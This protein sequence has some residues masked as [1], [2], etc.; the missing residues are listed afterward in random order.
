MKTTSRFSEGLGLMAGAI[1]LFF[2]GLLFAETP[3]PALVD[4]AV[5]VHKRPVPLSAGARSFLTQTNTPEVKVWVFFTDKQVFSKD[6]FHAQA[7][8]VT[9]LEKVL[10]RRAKVDMD[11]VLFVDL[12]VA[13]SYVNEIAALGGRL[14]HTSK[15]LNAASFEI[16]IEQLDKVASLPFVADVR[17]VAAFK[18]P[19]E[20]LGSSEIDDP[21]PPLSPD[22]LNYGNSFAQLNQINVPAVHAK[23][24]HGEGVTLAMFDTGYRKSHQVF[25]AHYAQGRV[26]AEWDFI[27][28]DGNTANEAVDWS[29]QWDHGTY[30]WST[31]GGSQDGVQ[32]GPAYKANFLLAKTEDVRSETRVEEDNWVAA[33]EWADGLGADVVTSSLGYSDWYT[34]ADFDGSTATTTLAANTAAGL[35]IVVC[36]SMGNGGPAAGTL[37]APADAFDI[38]AV[39]AV[40]S[41]GL[42]ASFSSRGPTYDGR[43]KPEVCARGVGTTCATSASD[44]SYGSASGTSLSTPLVAGAACLLIQ[45]RPSFTPQLIRAA[46]MET[47]S[48]ATTSDNTYG[49]GIIDVNKALTWGVNFYADTTFASGPLTV[50]FFD[51]S[52]VGPTNWAWSFG[53]GGFSN[54]QNPTHY[55][56]NPGAYDVSLTVGSSYG[57]I[58]EIKANY[59]ILLG[60]TAWFRTDSAFAGDQV[61]M[62]VDIVNSQPLDKVVI[63]FKFESTPNLG[64]SF[65]SVA[66]G[67][68]TNYF[69]KKQFLQSD[70]QNRKYTVELTADN[71]GGAPPLTPGTGEVLKIYFTLDRYAFGSQSN[72]VD[73][74]SG[75]YQLT[76]T[77]DDFNYQPVVYA[78]QIR[79]IYVLRGDVDHTLTHNVADISFLVA[80]LFQG[81]QEPVSF[82]AG[83][84]NRNFA[85]NVDDLTYM[86]AYLFQ[87]GPPP[88]TP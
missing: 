60:D 35:G 30:I 66:F 49:W 19:L 6:E 47:A 84:A 50:Q 82:Q 52:T 1:V 73:S 41:T 71:G 54:D 36:N 23:G 22:A 81:G 56:E 17:P 46:L 18:R 20:P 72:S 14:R 26:L 10:K 39:G 38:L 68:R 42:I 58:T 27:F 45:A 80:Y 62:S 37:T 11:R 8:S 43:T 13:A 33:L 9:L 29:S 69:E 87:G 3:H 74:S 12:P 24:F 44:L 83:D 75:V 85:I 28:G 65:D 31:A 53:D 34:Y 59:I 88:P 15:W 5:V 4:D 67:G 2:A 76:L 57:D 70:P 64:M 78:G 51:S 7:A 25:A 61:E 55:Y 48:R 63:P 40:S 16:A 32:Y 21:G 77:S 79:S 86:V